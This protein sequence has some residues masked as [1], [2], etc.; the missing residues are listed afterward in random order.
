MK[1]TLFD[2]IKS[3]LINKRKKKVCVFEYMG[4]SNLEWP[5]TACS[6]HACIFGGFAFYPSALVDSFNLFFMKE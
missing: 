6:K 4:R 1:Y 3:V 2:I 5:E